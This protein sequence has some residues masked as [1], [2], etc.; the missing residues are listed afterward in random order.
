MNWSYLILYLF[1]AYLSFGLVFGVWFV[2]KG[3]EQIDASM[4]GASWPT[5]LLLLPGSS[6]LWVVLLRKWLKNH[7]HGS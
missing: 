7:Q 6:A 4:H 3:A 5:R 1:Y 2:F